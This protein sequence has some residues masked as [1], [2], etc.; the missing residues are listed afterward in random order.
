[1]SGFLKM[2]KLDF[3][4]IKPQ[5]A[6][7]LSLVLIIVM[8]EFMDSSVI[9]LCMTG[10]WYVALMSSTIFAMQEKNSLERLYGS[11]SVGLKDIV[12]G[13]YVFVFLNYLVSFLVIVLL[14]CGF[15]LFQNR[16]LEA[17]DMMLGLSASFLA[18]SVITG[19]QM[20]MY[21]KLGYAK[22]KVWSMVPF[23][24]VMALMALIAIPS[25]VPALSGIIEWIQSERSAMILGGLLASFAV[26]IL[27]YRISVVFYRK[28]R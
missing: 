8:F 28:R 17:S 10:A 12:L 7:Y 21:F 23:M 14:H 24:A 16:A 2:T 6:A 18:F 3:Y 19:V 1:M 15:A 11:L 26:Q 27:S 20:P 25:F 9:V 5:L 4:T 13:R 22:A